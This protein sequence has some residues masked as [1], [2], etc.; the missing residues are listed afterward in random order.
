MER[1]EQ[2]SRGYRETIRTMLADGEAVA[3]PPVH[4][5]A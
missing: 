2:A 5:Q 4:M 1:H 3:V